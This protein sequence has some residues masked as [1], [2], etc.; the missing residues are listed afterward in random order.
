MEERI[1]IDARSIVA[2]IQLRAKARGRPLDDT[3]QFK[4]EKARLVRYIDKLA[5]YQARKGQAKSIQQSEGG[6]A[7]TRVIS[8]VLWS[9]LTPE[10]K[11]EFSE[12][13]SKR[14]PNDL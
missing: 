5:T 6:T 12:R 14:K 1:L 13:S 11:K 3:K 7:T 4:L 9:D 8:H 2:L 10:Q